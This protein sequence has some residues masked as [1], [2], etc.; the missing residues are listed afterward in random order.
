MPRALLLFPKAFAL[1]LSNSLLRGVHRRLLLKQATL[2]L[3]DQLGSDGTS[4]CPHMMSS[5]VVLEHAHAHA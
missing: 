4:L 1:P 5:L 3:A 2:C